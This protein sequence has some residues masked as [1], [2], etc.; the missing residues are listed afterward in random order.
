ANAL[1]LVE[2]KALLRRALIE[3]FSHIGLVS[4]TYAQG[5]P[6]QNAVSVLSADGGVFGRRS[7]VR[8]LLVDDQYELGFQYIL[9]YVLFGNQFDR[10][11]AT[12]RDDRWSF[13]RKNHGILTCVNKAQVLF[14]VL[15]QYGW[16]E[17]WSLPRK[18]CLEHDVLLLD[19]RLW[20]ENKKAD[21][22]QFMDNL[23]GLCRTLGAD[24]LEDKSFQ[25]AFQAANS[26]AEGKEVSEVP[27]LTL[28]PLLISHVD[29]AFPIILFSSTH[30]REVVELVAH[31]PNIVTSFSKPLMSGYGQDR[32]AKTLIGDLGR[33]LT[34]AIDLH[35][36]RVVWSGIDQ[37]RLGLEPIL[38]VK[39]PQA[40]L[41][42]HRPNDAVNPAAYRCDT[43]TWKEVLGY[44]YVHYILND[45]FVDF[46]SV[47]WELLEG[48]L[49]PED[50]LDTP[51][52]TNADLRILWSEEED[53]GG[54]KHTRHNEREW[55]ASP[56]QLIRHRK[57]HGFMFSSKLK[58]QSW[59]I[60]ERQCALLLFLVLIDFLRNV[61]MPTN[62]LQ[63]RRVWDNISTLLKHKYEELR[64]NGN[65]HPNK[66]VS[67]NHL[68]D[69]EF[70][71]LAIAA[72]IPH[73]G[74]YLAEETAKALQRALDKL[75]EDPPEL[76]QEGKFVNQYDN[77]KR[78]SPHIR[79]RWSDRYFPPSPNPLQLGDQV[80]FTGSYDKAMGRWIAILN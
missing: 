50:V 19:M 51:H 54:Q 60:T 27:A 41:R 17:N 38:Q 72:A 23:V 66:L 14:D 29:S 65:H 16:I 48:S 62:V 28:L 12:V 20:L 1:A 25:A 55:L 18:L 45:N 46:F 43:K 79:G 31:R 32:T 2:D 56:I 53:I 6:N 4:A 39:L 30:Q 11:Q 9:S 61:R 22:Q 24:R 33:A 57:T 64:I 10:S 36:D 15:T 74:W 37:L 67:D 44:C 42:I 26:L 3:V 75:L 7:D 73:G 70:V 21:R 59:G 58:I 63:Q 80:T 76:L 5:V 35:E 40:K 52:W 78:A 77:G 47:P 69:S 13:E 34:R 68:D 71:C 8:F 49:M